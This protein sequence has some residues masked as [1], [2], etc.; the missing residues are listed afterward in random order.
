M[1][2]PPLGVGY[3]DGGELASQWAAPIVVGALVSRVSG[4]NIYSGFVGNW[5]QLT[6]S[7][8]TIDAAVRLSFNYFQDSAMTFPAGA[9]NVDLSNA[10]TFTCQA[11]IP[12]LGPYVQIVPLVAGGGNVNLQLGVVPGFAV[13]GRGAGM[14]TPGVQIATGNVAAGASLVFNLPNVIPGRGVL[15][16]TILAGAVDVQIRARDYLGVVNIIGAGQSALIG[17]SASVTIPVLIP[18]ARITI[19]LRNDGAGLAAANLSLVTDF[20]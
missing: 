20:T 4:V 5:S 14:G 12:I 11:T 7:A 17:A 13:T 6:V 2:T 1:S 3:P 19:Q 9:V 8:T 10:D 16:G 18:P 15:M